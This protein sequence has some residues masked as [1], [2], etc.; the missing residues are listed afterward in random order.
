MGQPHYDGWRWGRGI[1]AVLL[2]LLVLA[3][4]LPSTGRVVIDHTT[5]PPTPHIVGR[6]ADGLVLCG[7]AAASLACIVLGIW[8]R[9][10]FEIVGWTMLVVLLV[11]SAIR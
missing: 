11:V 1:A 7:V 2:A 8:K 4:T 6:L 3:S 5:T 9:W 10:D